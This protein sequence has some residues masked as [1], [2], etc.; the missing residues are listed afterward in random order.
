MPAVSQSWSMQHGRSDH[1]YNLL[2]TCHHF[3]LFS[4]KYQWL[5][6]HQQKQHSVQNLP[7]FLMRTEP[8]LT[9]W[10]LLDQCI[11]ITT[12]RQATVHQHAQTSAISS[13]QKIYTILLSLVLLTHWKFISGFWTLYFLLFLSNPSRDWWFVLLLLILNKYRPDTNENVEI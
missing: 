4:T 13:P 11:A 9:M 6:L 12:P 2:L 10:T 1:S 3:P 8:N 5:I 7:K